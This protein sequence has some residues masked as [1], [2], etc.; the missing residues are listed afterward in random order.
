RTS[1]QDTP[2]GP[3]LVVKDSRSG[4]F[5]R[6][7]EAE[8]FILSQLDG[9]TT[10]EDIRRRAQAQLEGEL[11]PDTLLGFV[12]AVDRAGLLETSRGPRTLPSRRFK[13]SLLYLRIALFDP[14]RLFTTLNERLRFLFTPGFFAVWG[15]LLL[16]AIGITAANSHAFAASLSILYQLSSIP[17]LLFVIFIIASCHEFA[18][19]VT[20]KHFGGEVHEVGFLLMY[21]EPAFYTNVNDAWLFPERSKRLW[22]GSAGPIFELFVWSVA[23]VVWRFTEPRTLVN[24]VA[25]TVMALSGLKSLFDLNPFVKLDG[26]YLLSDY[27]ELPNLRRRSFAYV[28][29]LVKRILGLR[30]GSAAA[31]TRRERICY[32]IY[33]TIATAMTL[34]FIYYGL[35]MTGGYLLSKGQTAAFALLLTYA[36]MRVGRKVRRL[37]FPSANTLP[38]ERRRAPKPVAAPQTVAARTPLDLEAPWTVVDRQHPLPP[39]SGPEPADAP[40]SP[41]TGAPAPKP[42][43]KTPSGRPRFSFPAPG[44]RTRKTLWLGAAALVLTYLILGRAPLRVSGAFL[45]LPLENADVRAGVDG[46][47]QTVLVDEGDSVHAG[48]VIA[49]LSDKDLRAELSTTMAGI[50]QT[51]ANLNKLVAGPTADEIAVA[52]AALSKAADALHYNR[53]RL[54]RVQTLFWR[55]ELS[56]QDLDDATQQTALARGD[57][58]DAQSRLNILLQGSRPEDIAAARAGLQ[59]L[60]AQRDLVQRNLVLLDVVSPATGVVATPSRDLHALRGQMVTK[61]ELIAKVYD[62]HTIV[63]QI[64]VQEPDIGDVH[65][66]QPVVVRA[67]AFP[68]VSFGGRVTA[69]A[70]A[71]E[72]LATAPTP[73][74]VVPGAD[75]TAKTFLVTTEIDNSSGLLKPG[76]TG[77]AKILGERRRIIGLLG[78]RVGQTL[79][80]EVWSWF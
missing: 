72:G 29:T 38:G 30:T 3:V 17:L 77:Q 23:T 58:A 66:G 59:G 69:I 57:S 25:I 1:T 68:G 40:P 70:T 71:A 47:V 31:L 56:H 49:R 19:G 36:G 44:R 34:G 32:T 27:L 4:K 26:Y 37:F 42:S 12:D 45:A 39:A 16:L 51:R 10:L 67:R 8:R 22:V 53:D 20:C 55:G 62:L 65:V 60:E 11:S 73:D 48:Q 24:Y 52:R 46:I 64:A 78:R 61:G 33:G 6:F 5:F 21:F 80:V 18:H 14:D 75:A 9:R 13:G 41:P 74:A 54:A 35:E 43:P 15:T 2:G 7:R 50:G 28:G 63:A 76:M 79:K